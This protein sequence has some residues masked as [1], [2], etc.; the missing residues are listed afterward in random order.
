MAI[1]AINI[2]P[3]AVRNHVI[4]K[5]D[6]SYRDFQGVY[7]H[8][9]VSLTAHSVCSPATVREILPVALSMDRKAIVVIS[10]TPF[11]FSDRP[12]SH[13]LQTGSVESRQKFLNYLSANVIYH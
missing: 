10:S 12:I 1:N 4:P 3:E 8:S 2:D 13:T 9:V 6:H 11:F 5:F 7:P